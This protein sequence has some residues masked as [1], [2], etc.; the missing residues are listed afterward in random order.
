MGDRSSVTQ[1]DLP[2]MAQFST[3]PRSGDP[4]LFEGH[5]ILLQGSGQKFSRKGVRRKGKIRWWA[6]TTLSCSPSPP[7]WQ[8]QTH[9]AHLHSSWTWGWMHGY[10][11]LGV[12]TIQ[13]GLRRFPGEETRLSGPRLPLTFLL[14]AFRVVAGWGM[15]A[16]QP[17]PPMMTEVTQQN[18]Q[19]KA[20]TD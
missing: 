15:A 9:Q 4:L 12:A 20:G 3:V 2:S 5:L 13:V 1:H 10:P 14:P 11:Q 16:V 18:G 7:M 17:G 19:T 6:M 8:D